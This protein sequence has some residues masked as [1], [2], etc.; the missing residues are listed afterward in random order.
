MTLLS[1][2]K[3]VSSAPDI[4]DTINAHLANPAVHNVVSGMETFAKTVDRTVK[5]YQGWKGLLPICGKPDT[6]SGLNE[7]LDAPYVNPGIYKFVFDKVANFASAML[8]GTATMVA[9]TELY[10]NV[11]QK[12]DQLPDHS[13]LESYAL[14]GTLTGIITL[15]SAML[16]QRSRNN[17]LNRA[18]KEAHELDSYISRVIT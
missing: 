4:A 16:F 3:Q 17:V 5:P 11:V 14:Y 18:I 9:V 2:L 8:F 7:A 6:Q 13:R 15:G 12:M 10:F 1:E